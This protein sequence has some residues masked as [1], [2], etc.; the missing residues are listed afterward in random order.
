[1]RQNPDIQTPAFKDERVRMHIARAT[2]ID[3]QATQATAS[4]FCG[5]PYKSRIFME[6]L[7]DRPGKQIDTPP[8]GQ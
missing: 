2:R 6:F 8:Y 1:M 4:L 7:F 3:W 5:A